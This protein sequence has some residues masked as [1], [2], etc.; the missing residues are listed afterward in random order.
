MR[1]RPGW[2]VNQPVCLSM[3]VDVLN[4]GLRGSNH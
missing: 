4:G 2:S 3:S 1:G